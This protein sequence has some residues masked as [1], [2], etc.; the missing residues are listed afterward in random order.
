M[1]CRIVDR[2]RRSIENGKVFKVPIN[3]PEFTVIPWNQC[4]IRSQQ[5]IRIYDHL[6]LLNLLRSQLYLTSNQAI[7]YRL[8]SMRVWGGPASFSAGSLLPLRV[9]FYTLNESSAYSSYVADLE[10][11]VDHPRVRRAAVGFEWPIVQQSL[12]FTTATRETSPICE[13]TENFEDA[14]VYFRVWWR[15][16]LFVSNKPQPVEAT[17]CVH[18][19]SFQ[20]PEPPKQNINRPKNR[21]ARKLP[22]PKKRSMVDSGLIDGDVFALSADFD[23]LSVSSSHHPV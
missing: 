20:R 1:I 8:H 11:V 2:E 21:T 12:V 22:P 9:R 5:S 13:I 18:A 16:G 4:T 19:V 17:T 7:A 15:T 6:S 3:P 14:V 23:A 10:D